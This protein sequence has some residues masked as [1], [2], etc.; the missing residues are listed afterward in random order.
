MLNLLKIRRMWAVPHF[1]PEVSEKGAPILAKP[2]KI[3]RI[4]GAGRGNRTPMELPPT[5]FE[6]PENVVSL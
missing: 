3:N 6:F 2:L 5:N 1:A 4:D